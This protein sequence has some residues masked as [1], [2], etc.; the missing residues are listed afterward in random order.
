MNKKFGLFIFGAALV[1][2]FVG[3]KE[4]QLAVDGIDFAYNN[5]QTIHVTNN[6]S[7]ALSVEGS[8]M[9]ANAHS[10]GGY[11]LCYDSK[12]SVLS[13]EPGESGTIGFR[14]TIGL[15]IPDVSFEA[16]FK[17]GNKNLTYAGW[18]EDF[19]SGGDNTNRS[20]YGL[21]WMHPERRDD[22]SQSIVY[23]STLQNQLPSNKIYRLNA[24]VTDSGVSFELVENN[25]EYDAK[26]ECWCAK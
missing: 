8:A 21:L 3:C 17:Y 4:P 22:G 20:A 18:S 10:D 23:K 16:T 25:E 2:G 11:G 24:T 26:R 6:S 1:L 7:S 13:L 12:K 14:R 19:K 9:F 15:G 5:Y